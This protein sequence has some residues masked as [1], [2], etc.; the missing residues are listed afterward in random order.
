MARR[1][2][3]QIEEEKA[4]RLDSKKKALAKLNA[5]L[6]EVSSLSEEDANK[7]NSFI[8]LFAQCELVYKTLYPEMKRIQDN[9]QI[10]VRQLK[11]NVQKF[12]A[13]LRAFGISFD[14]DK[15]NAMF[16]AKKSYL[17]CRDGILHGLKK[18]SIDEVL[19]NYDEMQTAMREF[20]ECVANAE[21][22]EK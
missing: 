18:A 6:D 2:K 13:A 20:L 1:T 3:Q 17:T 22:K 10:D 12:E 16:S 4:Q 5:R 15:M 11:F 7:V 14:H 8:N 9:E 21:P 19:A